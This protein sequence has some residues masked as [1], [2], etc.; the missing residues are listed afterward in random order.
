MSRYAVATVLFG[1]AGVMA[2]CVPAK[3]TF[4]LP[5]FP[6]TETPSPSPNSHPLAS[7]LATTTPHASPSNPPASNTPTGAGS[8]ATPTPSLHH[9]AQLNRLSP[10][11]P[12]LALPAS[13]G[14]WA[15]NEDGSGLTQ[16]VHTIEDQHSPLPFAVSPDGRSLAFVLAPAFG[17][18]SENPEDYSLNLLHL[19]GPTVTHLSTLFAQAQI[20]AVAT[21]FPEFSQDLFEGTSLYQRLQIGAALARR[22]SIAWSPDGLRIAFVAALHDVSADVYI[23]NLTSGGILRLTS[24]LTHAAD[25]HWSPDGKFVVHQAIS[26]INVG[27]SGEDVVSGLWIAAADGSANRLAMHGPAHF[28]RWLGDDSFLAYFSEMGCGDYDLSLVRASTGESEVIWKG[29]FDA[30]DADPSSQ[31]VL[32]A[33]TNLDE[34]LPLWDRCPLPTEEG[35]FMIRLPSR[36]IHLVASLA[37]RDWVYQLAWYPSSSS[38]VIGPDDLIEVSLSG[39]V[40]DAQLDE[41]MPFQQ[42]PSGKWH[43][44]WNPVRFR[45]GLSV[46]D[47]MHSTI[48]IFD[49]DFCNALWDSRGSTLYFYSDEQNPILY[50]ASAPDFVAVEAVRGPSLSCSAPP[51]WIQP[52]QH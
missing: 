27:R 3:S 19:P 6:A 15:V 30:A 50:M 38:F 1:M 34:R 36:A 28:L 22:G 25:L 29:Q 10:S 12:W 32:V 13:D 2:S 9:N 47:E 18:D 33:L 43:W 21:Q 14:L 31:A 49:D 51:Q 39:D 4:S 44:T 41:P 20:R 45:D 48:P 40:S 37:G 17:N 35:L 46:V 26:D 23:Y 16:L 52:I 42:S 24:G 8:H 11:G 7:A 5:A